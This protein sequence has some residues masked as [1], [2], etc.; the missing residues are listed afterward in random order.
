MNQKIK[1]TKYEDKNRKYIMYMLFS[2]VIFLGF[3][4]LGIQIID[5]N[6]INSL[7]ILNDLNSINIIVGIIAIPSCLLYYYMYKNNEF[8]ILTLSYI[9][10]LIEYIYVNFII[11]NSVLIEQLITFTFVFR[12]FL[13]T[14]AIL[15]ES[16]YANRI[17]TNKR[18]YIVLAAVI[19]IIGVFIEVKFNV[20]DILI[21]NSRV[22]WNIF[23]YGIL[24]YYFIL[25]VLLSIRCVRKNIFIYTIFITTISIF[26]IRRL[27]YFN[28]F[29]KYSDKILEYNK[30]LTFIA[31]CILLIGLYIEVIRRI[32]ESIRLNNKVSDFNE[33]KIK[34]KEIKEIEKAKSQ[35]FANLSHEIKT[36]INIIYSC[37][38]LLEVNKING[39]KALSDAYNKY[40]NTLKQNCYRLL[41]LVNNLVD[42]T[43]IDSGYMKLIFINCEIVSLV[44]DI[45]LSIIPYVESKNINIVFD[46]YIEE[47]EIRCD[48]ESMERVILNLLSNAIKF[49]N[50]DGNISVIVEADDKYVFIRVKDDGIGISKDIREDIFNRF[51][52][53]D[54]SLNRKN[55]GSGIGLALVKSL[56]ELHDGEV[57][58]EDVSEGSEFVVKLPNIKINEEVNNHNRVM[59][60]ESKPLVQKINIEFSD[61]YELY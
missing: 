22:L 8:F 14:I 55:E 11:N 57:Y 10:I 37:I 39:E 32:E 18:K 47:L 41:R 1:L 17:V 29:L 28:M 48:P 19:N 16:K 5:I 12:V 13:L 42:M 34:Y 52:Q 9:S 59:D 40:D 45:T 2:T 21:S 26:T 38:Q 15:N 56:V 4:I 58:L 43:K 25:L 36:P 61:I 7:P 35:F 51:V 31:Y 20:N 54:K 27:F 60:V 49:T 44:E 3:A 6:S 33:L 46:T 50:N 30:T 53:E 23:Q 24:I